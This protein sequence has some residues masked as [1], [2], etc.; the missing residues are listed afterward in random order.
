[1]YSYTAGHKMLIQ[2]LISNS[3]LFAMRKFT[4][5]KKLTGHSKKAV[6]AMYCGTYWLQAL[7]FWIFFVCNK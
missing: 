1:M 4:L 3:A 5:A 2:F 7:G 6:K